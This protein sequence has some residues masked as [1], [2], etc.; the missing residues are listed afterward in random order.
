MSF[1]NFCY[2]RKLVSL[3]GNLWNSLNRL[4]QCT[5]VA[6]NIHFSPTRTNLLPAE[7][8]KLLG[9]IC[10]SC[11]WQTNDLWLKTHH[12]LPFTLWVLLLKVF[13]FYFQHIEYK[14]IWIFQSEYFVMPK[15]NHFYYAASNFNEEKKITKI[16]LKM[17]PDQ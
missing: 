2:E 11:T 16:I 9:N 8:L 7:D 10:S 13:F 17:Q 5:C 6:A 12:Q 4:H 1:H 14:L 15:V 3:Q